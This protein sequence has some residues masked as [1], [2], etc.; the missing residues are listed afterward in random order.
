MGRIKAYLNPK[1]VIYCSSSIL[2]CGGRIHF[3]FFRLFALYFYLII[4]PI[5]NMMSFGDNTDSLNGVWGSAVLS[6]L[7][8]KHL[9]D[10]SFLLEGEGVFS[11]SQS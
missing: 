7:H 1:K 3:S 6:T 4:L 10:S 5:T 9:P 8:Y 2:G 11:G